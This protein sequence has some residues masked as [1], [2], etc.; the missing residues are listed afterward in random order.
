MSRIFCCCPPTHCLGSLAGVINKSTWNE[1]FCNSAVAHEP[2]DSKA[3]WIRP[4]PPC[5]SR[6]VETVSWEAIGF[7]V[8]S[9]WKCPRKIGKLMVLVCFKSISNHT[10]TWFVLVI[11]LDSFHGM[12]LFLLL[13]MSFCLPPSIHVDLPG[14][15]GRLCCYSN[16]W[17]CHY[18]SV[19]VWYRLFTV[20]AKFCFAIKTCMGLIHLLLWFHGPDHQKSSISSPVGFPPLCRDWN[21]T[22]FSSQP[23]AWY[24][25]NHFS[26]NIF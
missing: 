12:I 3:R 11:H 7:M 14:W 2:I 15:W 23:W 10:K 1:C 4:P 6:P 20:L 21:K 24:L 25:P 22:S 16:F 13:P 19:V 17:A 5:R 8:K 9:S 18:C 26:V